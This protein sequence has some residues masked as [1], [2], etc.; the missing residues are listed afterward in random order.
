MTAFVNVFRENIAAI[1][2]LGVS[3]LVGFILFHLVSKVLDPT[4]L[5]LFETSLT[6]NKMLDFELL[7]AFIQ[8]RCK[9]LENIQSHMKVDNTAKSA[10]TVKS[11][12]IS[13]SFMTATNDK[14]VNKKQSKCVFCNESHSF[15]RC[16][17]FQQSTVKS[18]EILHVPTNCVS[19]T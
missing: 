4:K 9:I 5:R 10:T 11:R 2:E 18:V 15:Y 19:R 1:K 13:K 3:D 17:A 16:V 7:L 14:W 12:Q 6:P 8:Q